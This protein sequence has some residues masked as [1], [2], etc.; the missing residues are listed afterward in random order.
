MARPK[1]RLI[2]T[3]RVVLEDDQLLVVSRV[4]MAGWDVR[5]H[6]YTLIRFDG[7]TWRVASKTAGAEKTFHYQLVPCH[8]A[9]QDVSGP[10]IDYNL[11]YVA[12]RDHSLA[13]G[14]R[15][16]PV[17]TLLRIVSP[18]VGF[19]PARTKAR[20]EAVYGM[21]P[22]A[23]TFHSVFFEFL[24]TLGSVALSSIAVMTGILPVGPLLAIAVVA[25]V[26]GVVRWERIIG[27]ERPPPGFY[28]WLLPRR[29]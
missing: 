26:D 4:E 8:P 2:G 13:V 12:W 27:E 17:V 15:R 22:M 28:E 20:L 9:E 24:L 3:D 7:R 21:D 19:L 5:Q 16:G 1:T 6:R 11:D 10:E 14:R 29:R 18:L 23:S 25:G